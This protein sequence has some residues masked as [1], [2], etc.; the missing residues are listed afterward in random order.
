M[1]VPWGPLLNGGGTFGGY[2]QD[3]TSGAEFGLSCGHMFALHVPGA[4]PHE[5]TLLAT[6]DTRAVRPANTDHEESVR[7]ALQSME[8]QKAKAEKVE[9]SL[10]YNLE[11][12]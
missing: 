6:P 2:L 7:M 10:R 9:E 5:D 4:V 3:E 1:W 11:K 8:A 12:Q